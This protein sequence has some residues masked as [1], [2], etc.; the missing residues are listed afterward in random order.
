M[1]FLS[2]FHRGF[3]RDLFV[4]GFRDT[5][6]DIQNIDGSSV[7]SVSNAGNVTVAGTQTFTGNTTASGTLTVTGALT[8]SST[9]GVTGTATVTATDASA[10]AVGLAG[11]TNP[12]LKVTTS[13][14][15]QATGL[16]IIGNT[17]A[18]GVALNA[19]SSGAAEALTINAKGT[20]T[21]G[22]GPV[23]TGAVTI[24]PATAVTGILTPT[25]GVAASGGSSV[26]PRNFAAGNLVPAVST[27]FTDATPVVTETY[28]TEVFVPANCT[29]TGIALFNGSDVT[30]SVVV[31]LVRPG[32]TKTPIANSNLAGT[33]GSGTDAYQL[34]PFTAPIAL[35]GPETYFIL[36]Q[37]NSGTAR[38]NSPPLG[39]HGT[40]KKT[41]ET[42]GTLTTYT[43]PT[44]FS[45]NVGNI[46]SLY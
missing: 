4:R 16:Q 12:A 33:A 20:G 45:A 15:T 14:G 22:I 17:A 42:F 38:Y 10:L 34:I 31:G 7:F 44:T 46:A 25:G 24:T 18:S 21:I 37:Y 9:V 5:L 23:S 11:A 19:I 32:A 36:S 39:A 3:F 13:T 30:G 2:K 40:G 6:L 28:M 41:G 27:D 8:A 29:V 1:S 35:T 43:T 26:S